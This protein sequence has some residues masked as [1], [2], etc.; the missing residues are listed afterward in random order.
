MIRITTLA[1]FFALATVAQ[2]QSSV[3]QLA[4]EVSDMTGPPLVEFPNA[5]IGDAL[6]LRIALDAS[7]PSSPYAVDLAA[8]SLRVGDEVHHFDPALGADSFVYSPCDHGFDWFTSQFTPTP[9]LEMG[10]SGATCALDINGGCN[11]SWP[12]PGQPVVLT[13][14]G[15]PGGINAFGGFS[16]GNLTSSIQLNF[17]TTDVEVSI[18]TPG[19][20]FPCDSLPNTTGFQ[21]ELDTSAFGSGAGS[22]LHLECTHGP[23]GAFGF[24]F[25]GQGI[26]PVIN[27]FEGVHCLSQPTG[28]YNP[29]MA[30]N[31]GLPQLNSIAQ[32]DASGVLQNVS[33]TS[34]AGSG[35]DV[36]LELPYAPV[37]QLIHPG[38]QH[39]FQLWYRDVDTLGNP[40]ANFSNAILVQ[41]N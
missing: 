29:T 24:F 27:V 5:Q 31:Q 25:V 35:F 30:A 12:S 32:F 8:S 9:F 36:P 16:V 4:G 11:Q 14:T 1:S 7:T 19:L 37:G 39:S 10:G 3:L 22:D 20:E 23:P 17:A 33:G 34:A 13:G 2:A 18:S 41:F 6:V 38:D 28:R 21:A 40:T 15:T 26:G